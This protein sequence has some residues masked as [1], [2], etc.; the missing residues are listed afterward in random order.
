[1]KAIAFFLFASAAIAAEAPGA[2]SGGVPDAVV[3]ADGSGQYLTVQE[4]VHASP[5]VN[6]PPRAWT[7]LIKP[8]TYRGL[9]YVQ[10]E[11]RRLHLLGTEPGSTILTFDL[12][13]SCPGPDGRPIGTFRTPTVQVDADDFTAENLTFANSAGARGQALAVRVDGDRAIFR[14]CRFLGWQDTI[15][16]NRG[17]HY[18]ERC[19]IYGAVDFIF[20]GATSFFDHCQIVCRGDGYI[21]APSTPPEQPFGFV[22]ADCS[23]EGES[24]A[25]RTYLGRPWRPYGSSLFLRTRMSEVVRSSGWNNWEQPDREKTARFSESA[26]FGAGAAPA[27][28]VSWARRLTD[29]E[30]AAITIKRV[31]GGADGWVP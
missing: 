10:R 31:L 16:D 25:V 3:A 7:I 13:A 9:V 20:G 26:S 1:M 5:G 4:A 17:R 12:Y 2:G 21:T 22:F 11:K 24:G 28:R 8:G 15:L 18:Y 6:G 14:N 23:V 30:A 29:A 27:A 19:T